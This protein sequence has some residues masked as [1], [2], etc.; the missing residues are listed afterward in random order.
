MFRKIQKEVAFSLFKGEN[1]ITGAAETFFSQSNLWCRDFNKGCTAVA[2]SEH[3]TKSSE[4]PD[5]L[6]CTSH[7]KHNV[8][9][10]ACHPHRPKLP[11]TSTAM[12]PRSSW[13]RW[14]GSDPGRWVLTLSLGA[15][16]CSGL[17]PG[18]RALAV[19]A[20]GLVAVSLPASRWPAPVSHPGLICRGTPGCALHTVCWAF[21]PGSKAGCT[22]LIHWLHSSCCCTEPVPRGVERDLTYQLK[23]LLFMMF[24]FMFMF[25]YVYVGMMLPHKQQASSSFRCAYV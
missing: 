19:L 9:F 10:C 3:N 20:A 22:A 25:M 2:V 14:H 6:I 11:S 8:L 21:Q 23:L 17:P 1:L 12:N 16:L 7:S 18:K 4:H 15:Q 24:M 13:D 5:L